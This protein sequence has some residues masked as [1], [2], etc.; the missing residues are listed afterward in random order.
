MRTM[1]RSLIYGT[2]WKE[3][4]TGR[5]V[6]LALAAGFRAFDTANQRRHYREGAVGEALAAAYAAG[7][8]R[9][10]DLFL[11][12]KFTHVGGQDH[13]LPYDAKA[14]IGTQVR[15]S[16]AS[17]LEHL[18][19][20]AL[21]AYLLHGPST[22][23]GLAREDLEAWETMEALHHEGRVAA[24]GV[25][26]VTRAQLD[27]LLRRGSVRPS[28]VQNRCYASTGWDRETRALCRE[29][30]I[31]Y[32]GFSLLTANRSELASPKLLAVAKRLGMT[33]AQVVFRFALD[34][35][36]APLTGTTRREHMSEDLAVL[37]REPLGEDDVR[38]VEGISG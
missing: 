1:H 34:V 36:M 17:S 27:L 4:D 37:H 28:F 38:L 14:P 19:T 26:N 9:R 7:L 3:D 29:H 24:I 20:D 33:P 32:Q 2:A 22:R 5:L 30:G 8:V 10:E 16:F 23:S 18:H 25:S 21:D 12:T 13:R 6:G 31:V 11:Q 35:G 15:Q